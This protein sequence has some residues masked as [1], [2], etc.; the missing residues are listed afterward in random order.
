MSLYLCNPDLNRKCRR[1]RETGIC[2]RLCILTTMRWCSQDGH[3]LTEEE[4]E[5]YEN[6][7]RERVEP[8]LR[9]GRH[10]DNK[11]TPAA[12]AEEEPDT[13]IDKTERREEDE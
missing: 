9:I 13:E 6:Q 1:K 10:I 2:Q 11:T 4:V 12:A 7:L 8:G 3:Q 5:E